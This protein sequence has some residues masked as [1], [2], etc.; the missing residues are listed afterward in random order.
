MIDSNTQ[1]R[2]KKEEKKRKE[3]VSCANDLDFETGRVH[4]RSLSN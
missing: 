2:Q 4:V 3:D 1:V